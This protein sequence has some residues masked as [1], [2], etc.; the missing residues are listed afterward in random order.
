MELCGIVGAA[1]TQYGGSLHDTVNL[2]G[3][4]AFELH[5]P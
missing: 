5:L 1:V 4:S 2:D 3:I